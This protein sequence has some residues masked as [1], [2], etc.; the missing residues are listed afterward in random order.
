MSGTHDRQ[1]LFRLKALL[2]QRLPLVC[3][4]DQAKLK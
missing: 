1:R 3:S 2:I 4:V